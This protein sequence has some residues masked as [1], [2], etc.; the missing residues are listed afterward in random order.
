MLK[1]A[2]DLFFSFQNNQ[3]DYC[4]WKRTIKTLARADAYRKKGAIAIFDRYPQMEYAGIND[5]PKIRSYIDRF[6]IPKP[7]KRYFNRLADKEENNLKK[8]LA[9]QPDVVIKLLLDPEESIRRKPEESLEVV[10]KTRNH[11]EFRFF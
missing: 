1:K 4:H 9:I 3:I 5:G 11:S 8:A 7:I 2:S 6:S 10:K